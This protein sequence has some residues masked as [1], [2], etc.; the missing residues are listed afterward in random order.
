MTFLA[1]RRGATVNAVAVVGAVL[2]LE[3]AMEA[4]KRRAPRIADNVLKLIPGF[5]TR[6]LAALRERSATHF[7]E[8]INVPVLIMH[9]GN[10][11]EYP[12][13]KR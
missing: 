11:E 8:Q 3:N 6:G 5:P 9:G 1:L 10:D 2:D 4:T 13:P 12:Q 7:A